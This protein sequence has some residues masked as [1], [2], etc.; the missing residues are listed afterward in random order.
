VNLRPIDLARAAGISTQQVRNHEDEGV[1]PPVR[2]TSTGYRQYTE[3][4]LQALVTFRALVRG[5]GRD[6]ARAIMRSVHD[7]DL[8]QA[9]ALLDAGH[10]DLHEQRLSLRAA[11]DA[12]AAITDEPPG[13]AMLTI[14][15]VAGHLRVRPSA[16][17]VWEAAGLLSPRRTQVSGYRLFDAL[18][19]RDARIIRTLRQG[20]YG[21]AEIRPVIEGLRGTGS[22]EALRRVVNDRR[23][24][25]A[26][27]ARAALE[28]SAK[29][30]GYLTGPA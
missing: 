7:G 16:L 20:R 15:E 3:Q 27:Q 5:Y 25:L 1:L 12:L 17:R 8:P 11:A 23:A 29:L 21:L 19:V 30:Y 6:T 4:H 14:G 9:Y 24:A 10:A 18:D 22:T 2:R 28:A 26:E 13:P